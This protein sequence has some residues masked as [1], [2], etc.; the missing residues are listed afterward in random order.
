MSRYAN[1]KWR[2][3]G[4]NKNIIIYDN[5]IILF[6]PIMLLPVFRPHLGPSLTPYPLSSTLLLPLLFFAINLK[7]VNKIWY[8]SRLCDPKNIIELLKCI[9]H[10]L[11]IC[12]FRLTCGYQKTPTQLLIRVY[13]KW[14]CPNIFDTTITPNE[15]M[16]EKALYVRSVMNLWNGWTSR[17]LLIRCTQNYF[18]PTQSINRTIFNQIYSPT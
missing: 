8:I 5:A 2:Y 16:L 4:L 11:K 3:I 13:W 14:K 12:F 17:I 9:L 18:F 7:F 10:L 15:I 1:K 6:D